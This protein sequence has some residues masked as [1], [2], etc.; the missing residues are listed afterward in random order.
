MTYTFG[1]PHGLDLAVAHELC[2]QEVL[3]PTCGH[4]HMDEGWFARFNRRHHVCHH[5]GVTF[6]SPVPCV[7]V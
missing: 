3:C 6:D 2:L 1:V 5:C 7:G 4:G